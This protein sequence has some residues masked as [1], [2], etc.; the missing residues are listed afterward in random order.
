M[1]AAEMAGKRLLSKSEGESLHQVS[2]LY[3]CDIPRLA[4]ETIHL[5]FLQVLADIRQLYNRVVPK[6]FFG[7]EPLDRILQKASS[8]QTPNVLSSDAM[9]HD[10]PEQFE[11]TNKDLRPKPMLIEI[12]SSQPWAGKSLLLT[13][14]IS[15]MLLPRSGSEFKI[16]GRESI[17][18]LA[19]GDGKFDMLLLYQMMKNHLVQ[20][21]HGDTS[22]SALFSAADEAQS[23]RNAERIPHQLTEYELASVI[24]K[25]LERL[26]LVRPKSLTSLLD[27]LVDLPR[28]LHSSTHLARYPVGLIAVD[29]A[30][31]YFWSHR[32]RTAAISEPS[33][34]LTTLISLLPGSEKTQTTPPQPNAERS[35]NRSFSDMVKLLRA[36][37]IRFE[38]PV[39]VTTWDPSTFG[40]GSGRAHRY[41][42]RKESSLPSENTAPTL[43]PAFPVLPNVKLEVNRIHKARMKDDIASLAASGVEVRGRMASKSRGQGVDRFWVNSHIDAGGERDGFGLEVDAEGVVT[44]KQ[45]PEEVVNDML[46]V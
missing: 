11:P 14:L 20:A 19:D 9:N 16:G 15:V 21:A 10:E 31:T 36:Q 41:R 25:S 5:T 8:V 26:Y 6:A 44:L 7:I 43:N 18:V 34:L 32:A 29:S 17:V 45:R 4:S 12:T 23:N 1:S 46:L 28:A 24:E 27:T 40:N 3:R 30:T 35:E 2:S 33:E 37:S 42:R 13:H 38:C 22:S 39:V